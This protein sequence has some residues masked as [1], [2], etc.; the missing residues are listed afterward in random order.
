MPQ[1]L[2][3]VV[4]A[5][6]NEE[7]GYYEGWA[8]VGGEGVRD[9]SDTHGVHMYC[10]AD[11]LFSP[12]TMASAKLM[13]VTPRHPAEDVDA[14][15][16]NDISI[17]VT[18]EI[19][20]RRGNQMAIYFKITAAWAIEE[21][22][23]RKAADL[24]ILFS[25]GYKA[26]REI[27]PGTW[28]GKAY[29]W[30]M[31]KIRMNHLALLLDNSTPRHPG[32]GELHDSHKNDGEMLLFMDS[33]LPINNPQEGKRVLKKLPKGQEVDV[34]DSTAHVLD[35]HL[36]DHKNLQDDYAKLE[37][38][39]EQAER[40]LQNAKTTMLDSKA[41]DQ[42]IETR[43][44]LAALAL[45]LLDSVELVDLAKMPPREIYESVLLAD[46]RTEEQLKEIAKKKGDQYDAYLSGVF[47]SIVDNRGSQESQ[48]IHDAGTR[49]AAGSMRGQGSG[50][51]RIAAAK[52]KQRE[53]M[54]NQRKGVKP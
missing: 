36:I 10:P 30:I 52:K 41:V 32:T 44:E 50:E 23:R 1:L 3:K 26:F 24:P 25:L 43:L 20:E 38:K 28:M 42:T 29:Q 13:P 37:G 47:D 15:N 18:G 22:R 21:I 6:E 34:T 31:R 49:A 8:I 27:A 12:E 5:Q 7:T 4:D 2:L 17:G 19:P 39:L 40:N 33:F 53:R 11:E 54:E 48:R 35:N 51:D 45:P 16:W 46:G 14:E 9:Y